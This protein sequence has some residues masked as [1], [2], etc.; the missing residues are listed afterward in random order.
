M[1]SL[2]DLNGVIQHHR[3]DF[4]DVDNS[5]WFCTFDARLKLVFVLFMLFLNVFVFKIVFSLIVFGLCVGL[6]ILSG[7]NLVSIVNKLKFPVILGFVVFIFQ[8]IFVKG[9]E[10]LFSFGGVELYY[11]GVVKGAQMFLSIISGVWLLML[12]SLTTPKDKI[13]SGF[14]VLGFP[15]ILIDISILIYRYVF[16]LYEEAIRVY[17][18]QKV[19]L[20]YKDFVTSIKSLGNLAGI[21][22]ISSLL[23]SQRVSEAMDSRGYSGS[24]FFFD[25]EEIE[26]KKIILTSSVMIV[27]LVTGI[28]IKLYM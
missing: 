4:E 23:R 27:F 1:K 8:S 9:G 17:E 7:V 14:V 24:L 12:I 22:L 26:S 10:L 3:T 21:I 16:I 2:N 25:R 15:K 13:L 28:L 19:R 6:T 5:N 18:A 11:G 20:G